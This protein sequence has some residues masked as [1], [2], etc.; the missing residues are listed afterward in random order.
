MT[1]NKLMIWLSVLTGAVLVSDHWRHC[2]A[3]G[4][5]LRMWRSWTNNSR[6]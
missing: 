3:G 2:R 6:R 1:D 5:E 4:G